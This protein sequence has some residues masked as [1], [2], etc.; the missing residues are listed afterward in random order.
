MTVAQVNARVWKE[1]GEDCREGYMLHEVILTEGL[2][3]PMHHKEIVIESILKWSSW[4][5]EDR[6]H[7]CFTLKAI[8]E[9]YKEALELAKPPFTLFG[10]VYYSSNDKKRIDISALHFNKGHAKKLDFKVKG[11]YLTCSRKMSD[12]KHKGSFKWNNDSLKRGA[13]GQL[14]KTW[15][16]SSLLNIA[17]SPS[18]YEVTPTSI[19]S[20]V[21]TSWRVTDIWCYY[22]AESKRELPT[23]FNLV[24][25]PK[26]N[27]N[28]TRSK[29]RPYFGDALSF[30]SKKTFTEFVAA[31][32]VAE[33]DCNV[34]PAKETS[35]SE[36]GIKTKIHMDLLRQLS[37]ISSSSSDNEKAVLDANEEPY[38]RDR[39]MTTQSCFTLLDD[40]EGDKIQQ[41]GTQNDDAE[42]ADAAIKTSIQMLGKQFSLHSA[43]L[44]NYSSN[45]ETEL[46]ASTD[47]LLSQEQISFR[48]PILNNT[49]VKSEKF[50]DNMRDRYLKS[51][52]WPH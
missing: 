37:I 3:R 4:S 5:D 22:G 6:K 26:N 15:K 27:E 25:I 24:I 13:I 2:E 31:L 35:G 18:S 14:K 29:S 43:S 20:E 34:K 9:Q 50:K 44:H 36:H 11:G 42:G 21:V 23:E 12:L 30:E 33:H 38:M 16:S 8:S 48:Q 45:V 49:R 28:L 32:L 47:D 19:S 46:V 51:V 7:N 52:S 39:A 17:N 40:M 41:D 1:L 10:E